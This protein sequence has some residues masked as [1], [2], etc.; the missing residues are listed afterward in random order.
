M[1]TMGWSIEK[2]QEMGKQ[3]ETMDDIRDCHL[4]SESRW[5]QLFTITEHLMQVKMLSRLYV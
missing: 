2:H 1:T 4:R 5:N 3:W